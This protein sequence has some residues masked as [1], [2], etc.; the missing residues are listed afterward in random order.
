MLSQYSVNRLA[1]VTCLNLYM[2]RA[3]LARCVGVNGR[4]S[5][6]PWTGRA[7]IYETTENYSLALGPGFHLYDA[8]PD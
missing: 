2:L 5:G 4:G 1:V 3:R 8:A 6:P 7:N